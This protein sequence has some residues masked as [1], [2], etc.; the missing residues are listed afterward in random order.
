M[1]QSRSSYIHSTAV[2]EG[3]VELGDDVE[4]GAFVYIKGPVSIGAGSRIFT[5]AKIGCDAEHSSAASV[6]FIRIGERCHIRENVTVQRGTGDRDT[7]IGDDVWCMAHSHIGHD[8]VVGDGVKLSPGAKLGGHTRVH[9]HATI[10]LNAVTHQ[11]TTLGY[12][13]MVGA[14]AVVVKDVP[15]FALVG[16]V[17]AE[18][19]RWNHKALEAWGANPGDVYIEDGEM[20]TIRLGIHHMLDA[21]RSDSRRTEVRVWDRPQ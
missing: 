3:T 2:L 1:Q 13:C 6:G 18:F 21:F 8:C 7:T 16:G 15:P 12:G 10:G 17:P 20:R 5:G 14:G 4:V 11:R 9:A 19:M